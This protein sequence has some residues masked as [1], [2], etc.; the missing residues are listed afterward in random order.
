MKNYYS[1]R[2]IHIKLNEIL[3]LNI[4]LEI[5]LLLQIVTRS[6]DQQ[7]ILS[8]IFLDYFVKLNFVIKAMYLEIKRWPL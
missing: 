8:Y 5:N 6:E 1:F 3:T 2:F 7:N 4:Y